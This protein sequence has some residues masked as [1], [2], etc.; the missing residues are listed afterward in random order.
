MAMESSKEASHG[1]QPKEEFQDETGLELSLGL[2]LSSTDSRQTWKASQGASARSPPLV[3]LAGEPS[4]VAALNGLHPLTKPKP[5]NKTSG[6]DAALKKFLEGRLDDQEEN[7]KLLDGSNSFSLRKEKDK[8]F[9]T[10]SNEKPSQQLETVASDLEKKGNPFLFK[11]LHGS[12]G[13]L[14]TRG[15]SPADATPLQLVDAFKSTSNSDWVEGAVHFDGDDT[16]EEN[17]GHQKFL[18]IGKKRKHIVE[19]Q[20][21]QKK[22]KKE[23][24]LLGSNTW[25]STSPVDMEKWPL[26]FKGDDASEQIQPG[27]S[28]EKQDSAEAE[29]RLQ[30]KGCESDGDESTGCEKNMNADLG[31]NDTKGSSDELKGGEV[32]F[33]P[34]LK[35]IKS[36]QRTVSRAE[37]EKTWHLASMKSNRM[38]AKLQD[39]ES[40]VKGLS[41]S[42]K[43]VPDLAVRREVDKAGSPLQRTREK[44]HSETSSVSTGGTEKMEEK[45]RG[46]EASSSVPE[47]LA[48]EKASTHASTLAASFCVPAATT[49]STPVPYAASPYSVMPMPYSLPPSMPHSHGMSFPVGA[50]FPYMMQYVP[51]GSESSE[52]NVRPVGNTP[53]QPAKIEYPPQLSQLEGASWMQALRPPVHSPFLNSNN[54]TLYS[55]NPMGGVPEDGNVRLSAVG[56]MNDNGVGKASPAADTSSFQNHPLFR[57]AVHS[58]AHDQVPEGPVLS[59]LPIPAVPHFTSQL[60]SSDHGELR[61]TKEQNGMIAFPGFT[62]TVQ[63]A[64]AHA[65]PGLGRPP[66]S[67]GAKEDARQEQAKFG[68]R[69]SSSPAMQQHVHNR[70]I[71]EPGPEEFARVVGSN[72]HQGSTENISILD[73][74]GED[75]SFLQYGMAPGLKFGGTGTA[76]D[77][78]WVHTTGSSGQTIGG[79]LYRLSRTEFRIVCACHGKHM[80]T[81]EFAQHASGVDVGNTDKNVVVN[82]PLTTHAA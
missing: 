39:R 79:V 25:I 34:L 8:I 76:P 66:S 42:P 69:R 23:E 12:T 7:L 82:S 67:S 32:N 46:G 4:A 60:M 27:T 22:G 38:M 36:V 65:L 33:I 5:P 19:E 3:D 29:M 26:G 11:E 10:G 24:T 37:D 30:E 50:N 44:V 59:S 72:F 74:L 15:Q 49:S 20:K 1:L 16:T 70:N 64:Q 63:A 62:A 56:R 40:P 52:Q 61:S 35:P 54:G 81:V 51:P 55:R 13:V 45:N 58:G 28:L 78:P 57:M 75:M 31:Q 68:G 77:L 48:S 6:L 41:T 17:S 43:D 9:P 80:S 18:D 2:S 14:S 71:R 21:H 73:G 53:F 47:V